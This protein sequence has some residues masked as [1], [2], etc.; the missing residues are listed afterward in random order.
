[1]IL[2]LGVWEMGKYFKV[3]LPIALIIMI[4]AIVFYKKY[5]IKEPTITINFNISKLTEDKFNRLERVNYEDSG[6]SDFRILTYKVDMKQ[7][8]GITSRKIVIPDI[9]KVINTIDKMRVIQMTGWE[10]DNSEEKF[11]LYNYEFIYYSKGLNDEDVKK[12]LSSK[13]ITVSWETINGKA[14]TKKF[15]VGNKTKIK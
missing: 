9:E 14:T 8:N 12:A 2:F 13:V 11:A 3:V 10:Q 6:I 7:S 5:N 4:I 1:M 15:N